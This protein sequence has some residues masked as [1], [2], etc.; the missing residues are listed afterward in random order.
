MAVWE[1]LEITDA[2][3][4]RREGWDAG[5]RK[6]RIEYEQ[7]ISENGENNRNEVVCPE[8]RIQPKPAIQVCN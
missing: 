5:G 2:R 1:E 3:L 6:E 4:S 8:K 7:S